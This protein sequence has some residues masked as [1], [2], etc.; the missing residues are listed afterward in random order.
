[1]YISVA[2]LI[3]YLDFCFTKA[4]CFVRI[5]MQH[6]HWHKMK[7]IPHHTKGE[8]LYLCINKNTNKYHFCHKTVLINEN[9]DK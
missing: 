3:F 8:T 4:K 5:M 6:H 1:M 9:S 2:K 7:V